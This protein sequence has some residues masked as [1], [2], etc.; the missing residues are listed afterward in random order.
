MIWVRTEKT[1]RDGEEYCEERYPSSSPLSPSPCTSPSTSM[2]ASLAFQIS[3]VRF[4]FAGLL[5]RSCLWAG[6]CWN[7]LGKLADMG[8]LGQGCCGL[9][10][11]GF[12]V[13]WGWVHQASFACTSTPQAV[14]VANLQETCMHRNSM[15]TK[16]TIHADPPRI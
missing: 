1:N 3:G 4:S 9:S 5:N 7:M 15:V 8:S 2:W 10:N 16:V 11:V 13:S 6:M 12:F 14:I